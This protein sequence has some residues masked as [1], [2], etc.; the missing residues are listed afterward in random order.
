[1]N[2]WMTDQ[3]LVRLFQRYKR[4]MEERIRERKQIEMKIASEALKEAGVEM[5]NGNAE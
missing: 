3:D 1:M 2:F 4:N 5:N